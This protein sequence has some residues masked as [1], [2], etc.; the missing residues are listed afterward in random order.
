MAQLVAKAYADALMSVAVEVGHMEEIRRGLGFVAD[1]LAENPDFETLFQAPS[2]NEQQKKS[3]VEE[4]FAER[5]PKEVLNFVKLLVDKGRESEL[6]GIR[7]LFDTMVDAREGLIKGRARTSVEMTAQQIDALEE[8]LSKLAGMKVSLVNVVD[9]S[10]LGGVVL[11]I[12]DKMIDGSVR[13]K[14]AHIREE[15]RQVVV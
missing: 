10:I 12:G 2:I 7:K 15:L 3:A 11:E 14:L 1:T 13:K 6:N 5:V 4:V 8:R 9:E